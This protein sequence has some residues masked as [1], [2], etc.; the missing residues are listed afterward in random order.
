MRRLATALA[1]LAITFSAAACDPYEAIYENV[2]GHSPGHNGD[3]F[4]GQGPKLPGPHQKPIT[5][6]KGTTLPGDPGPS[7]DSNTKELGP[8]PLPNTNY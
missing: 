8:A 7:L 1:L 4:N 3:R 6:H 2:P 5:A